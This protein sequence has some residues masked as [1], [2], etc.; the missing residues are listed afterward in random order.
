MAQHVILGAI[1]VSCA[2]SYISL[3]QK[4]LDL[5]LTKWR[6]HQLDGLHTH[7]AVAVPGNRAIE[8]II[9]D[10][11]LQSAEKCA[12]WSEREDWRKEIQI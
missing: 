4:T 10:G 7:D 8:T 11:A 1:E 5:D 2:I 9:E 12:H 3:F 6:P